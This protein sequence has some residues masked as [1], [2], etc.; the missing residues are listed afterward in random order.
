MIGNVARIIIVI[1]MVFMTTDLVGQDCIFSIDVKLENN[2]ACSN[3]TVQLISTDSISLLGFQYTDSLGHAKIST[4]FQNG[5]Y[6]IRVSNFGYKDSVLHLLCSRNDQ[7]TIKF[8]LKPLS[9]KLDEVTVLDKIALLKKSGDTTTFNLKAFETGSEISTFDIIR[10]FPGIEISDQGVTYHGK[11]INDILVGDIDISDPNQKQLLENLR[12]DLIRQIQILENQNVEKSLDIDS[13]DLGL[14]M[15]IDLEEQAKDKYLYGIEAGGGY[16]RS[17]LGKG[18]VIKVGKSNGLRVE[19]LYNNSYDDMT[20]IEKESILSDLIKHELYNSRYKSTM[21]SSLPVKFSRH[22]TNKRTE[23]QGRIVYSRNTEN[24]LFKSINNISGLD[25]QS[26]TLRNEEFLLDGTTF[27]SQQNSQFNIISIHSSSGYS[28]FVSDH[29]SAKFDLPVYVEFDDAGDNVVSFRELNKLT[30]HENLTSRNIAV[31]PDYRIEHE[32]NKTIF[33]LIGNIEYQN[34]NSH[35]KY[36]STDTLFNKILIDEDRSAFDQ[37]KFEN[38]VNSEHQLRLT[39][40]L[41]KFKVVFNSILGTQREKL[42]A[43]GSNL[44][45]PDFT[46]VTV[47]KRFINDN[48]IFLKYEGNK[49]RL[50]GGIKQ[51]WLDQT[52]DSFRTKYQG[53]NPYIFSL[54]KLSWKWNISSSFDYTNSLPSIYHLTDIKIVRAVQVIETG[55]LP[56]IA[57]EE[58]KT[59]SISLFKDFETG[60]NSTQFNFNVAYILPYEVFFQQPI[61]NSTSFQTNW[62]LG[63][64]ENDVNVNL[65]SAM[66]RRKWHYS[67][68]LSSGF[69]TLRFQDLQYSQIAS[70]VRTAVK[71]R[72]K[73]ISWHS[74]LH[75]R[76]TSTL[77]R[78]LSGYNLIDFTNSI[79]H[80]YKKFSQSVKCAFTGTSSDSEYMIR[81][82]I[83]INLN[84]A[85]PHRNLKF[86]LIGANINNL[87]KNTITTGNFSLQSISIVES[88]LQPGSIMILMK[89]LF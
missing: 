6:I 68:R 39:H 44:S 18:S 73:R 25:G 63:G 69:Q 71:Y 47:L 51:F 10:R 84:Y 27:N 86:S 41:G 81:P 20:K 46:G 14:I 77:Q 31:N 45:D 85:I 37:E 66:Y 67:L 58:R 33:R 19:A 42:E 55:R 83:S 53:V 88:Y 24:G 35:Q 26:K 76:N 89:K 15:K 74:L 11:N 5:G 87:G 75:F 80:E 13:A 38:K 12:Y 2:K 32:R 17:Y 29:I 30:T 23:S 3:C 21:E 62:L 36:F 28:H 82:I 22:R 61:S 43:I 40:D 64:V 78:S 1:L 50:Q 57:R 8:T 49:F 65:Y 48:A 54:Y 9:I 16:L 59:I 52:L 72:G 4:S 7:T 34:T 60:E 70:S 79:E 56:Y